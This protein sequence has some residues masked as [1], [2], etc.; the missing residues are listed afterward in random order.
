MTIQKSYFT[1]GLCKVCYRELPATIE[2][3]TDGAAYMTKTCPV[4]GHQE[5]MVEKSYDFW[6]S[7][8]QMNPDNQ[9]WDVYNNVSTIEVTDRCNV[10]CKHC[11]HDPDNDIQDKPL[12]WIIKTAKAAP[13]HTVCL[14]L[15]HI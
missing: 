8:T 10:Q 7:I 4:H 14:S 11:Y 13:G 2:Y 12:E 5:A 1:T 3:R 9:C 15:I 6:D